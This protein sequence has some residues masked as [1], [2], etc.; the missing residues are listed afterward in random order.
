MCLF[1]VNRLLKMAEEL[2]L[3]PENLA[4]GEGGDGEKE[5]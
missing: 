5:G 3:E 2:A 1:V 4:E